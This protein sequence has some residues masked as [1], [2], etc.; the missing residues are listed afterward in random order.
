MQ[1][2]EAVPAGAVSVAQPGTTRPPSSEIRNGASRSTFSDSFS[3]EIAERYIAGSIDFD[4]ADC[5]MNA[6][7]AMTPPEDFPS[8]TRAVY[9]AFDEGEYVQPGQVIGSDE[10]VYTR[11]LLRQAMS[12]FH[13]LDFS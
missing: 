11:P 13:P 6:L 8:Y 4:I 1:K 7:F 12:D 3:K 5:A 10:D 2:R 9:Q